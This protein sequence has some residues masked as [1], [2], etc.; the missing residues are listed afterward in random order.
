MGRPGQASVEVVGPTTTKKLN[1]RI[2]HGTPTGS[3]R[4]P[5]LEALR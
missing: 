2:V 4:M 3:R 5:S 1:N